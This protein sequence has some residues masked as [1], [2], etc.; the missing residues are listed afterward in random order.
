[1]T[2]FSLCGRGQGRPSAT[3]RSSSLKPYSWAEGR[4]DGQLKADADE[5]GFNAPDSA[6]CYDAPGRRGRD[7]Y[8]APRS[9][10]RVKNP[11]PPREPAS[12]RVPHPL[13]RAGLDSV[14]PRS[15]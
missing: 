4:V 8:K 3:R 1:M 6:I 11:G 14:Q 13:K 5:A 7:R 12:K 2:S 10:A 15:L 9:R